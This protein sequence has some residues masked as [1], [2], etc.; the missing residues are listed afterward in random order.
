MGYEPWWDEW[1]EG[2]ADIALC[3]FPQ[4]QEFLAIIDRSHI[5]GKPMIQVLSTDRVQDEHLHMTLE[6]Q[7]SSSA[8][9]DKPT[10]APEDTL[11]RIVETLLTERSIDTIVTNLDTNYGDGSRILV[12]FFSDSALI[13][14]DQELDQ[15]IREL[16]GDEAEEETISTI[17]HHLSQLIGRQQAFELQMEKHSLRKSIRGQTSHFLTLWQRSEYAS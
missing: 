12:V 5:L 8:P 16:A 9:G 11:K 4:L 1:E 13:Q 2:I 10:F 15:T 14:D 6:H 17:R 7:Y 3:V